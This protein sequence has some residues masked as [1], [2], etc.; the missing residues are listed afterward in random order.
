MSGFDGLPPVPEEDGFVVVAAVAAVPHGT[1]SVMRGSHRNNR[2][3]HF[4]AHLIPDRF[5]FACTPPEKSLTWSSWHGIGDPHSTHVKLCHCHSG[6]W[7]FA[8]M[9]CE[10]LHCSHFISASTHGQPPFKRV[11]VSVVLEFR[12]SQGALSGCI[13]PALQEALRNMTRNLDKP[14]LAELVSPL[15]GRRKPMTLA[16]IVCQVLSSIVKKRLMVFSE[17]FA[18]TS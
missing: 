14:A 1:E 7:S 16:S 9:S 5:R 3:L 11:S 6:C 18:N 10:D 15:A 12:R 4:F 2:G 8:G 13:P 17:E